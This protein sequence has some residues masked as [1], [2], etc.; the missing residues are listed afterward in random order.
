MG[1]DWLGWDV[2]LTPPTTRAPLAV[3]INHTVVAKE[4]MWIQKHKVRKLFLQEKDPVF[5]AVGLKLLGDS[6]RAIS[7]TRLHP[8]GLLTFYI[9]HSTFNI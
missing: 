9:L 4:G 8:G 5:R 2:S 3:L 7:L 1:W 6:G